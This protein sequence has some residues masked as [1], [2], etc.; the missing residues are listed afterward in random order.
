[1]TGYLL[2]RLLHMLPVLVLASFAIFAMIYAVPGG[3]VA[4]LVGENASPEEIAATIARYGLDRP[5]L[6]QYLDWLGQALRGDFGLSLHS[7]QPVLALIGERLPATLQ[8]AVAA[9]LVALL[10]GIP[11]AVASAVRPNSWLDRL[12]S[13]WSAL[14]LGV[15]TFW[16]GILLI[17]LFAVELHWLPSASRY[18]PFWESPM[19]ALRSLILPALTL[20]IYVSGIFARFLRASLIGEAKQDYVRTARAKGLPESRVVGLHIMRNALLP[21]VTIVGLMMANFIGGAVVTEAVFTYP[22]LGRLVIQAIS[23]RDYPLIQGCIMVILVGYML[24]NLIIDVL[25]AW[26]DPRIEYH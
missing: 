21:F 22:G 18:V 7:R 13:G 17:L 23:T 5:M 20:G 25:Y 26:I 4:V 6:I 2:R 24:V 19:D 16:L 3:P 14:A 11:V 1:M 9:I 12:L 8:L 10:V 15:P